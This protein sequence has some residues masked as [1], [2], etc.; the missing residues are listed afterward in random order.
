MK[1]EKDTEQWAKREGLFAQLQGLRAEAAANQIEEA[2]LKQT[3]ENLKQDK[4]DEVAKLWDKLETMK[5]QLNDD[6]EDSSKLLY[7]Q[8]T[9]FTVELDRVQQQL[10]FALEGKRIAI[11]RLD[12]TRRELEAAELR[13]ARI[14]G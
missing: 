12:D 1:D 5:L 9:G 7:D 4:L 10:S 3:K 8:K 6:Q 11:A 2:E 14:M 13:H